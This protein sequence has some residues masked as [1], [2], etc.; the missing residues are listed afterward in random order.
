M[1]QF[2]KLAPVIEGLARERGAQHVEAFVAATAP[3]CRIN[4]AH[5]DLGAILAADTN[6]ECE[7]AG[8]T[9]GE[10]SELPGHRNRMPQ[11]EEIDA[12]RR[13]EAGCGGQIRGNFKQPVDAPPGVEADVVGREHVVEPEFLGLFEHRPYRGERTGED[14]RR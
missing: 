12:D 14:R 8:E 6:P 9:L 4:A 1:F 10:T 11:R 5:L 13:G 2:E 3:C 7:A